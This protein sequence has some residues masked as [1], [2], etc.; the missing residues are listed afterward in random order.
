[1]TILAN[2]SVLEQC[3]SDIIQ[4]NGM[5]FQWC[6]CRTGYV[7][8]W[9]PVPLCLCEG[10]CICACGSPHLQECMNA[11][12]CGQVGQYVSVFLLPR[13]FNLV[14]GRHGTKEENIR[15]RK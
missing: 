8:L 3:A 15:C 4:E 12:L 10:L 2:M 7:A 6:A 11:C 13:G 14:G 1:M 9:D 5:S